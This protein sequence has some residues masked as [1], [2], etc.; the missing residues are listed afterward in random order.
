MDIEIQKRLVIGIFAS[1]TFV[2]SLASAETVD[3]WIMRAYEGKA[4]PNYCAEK[5]IAADP[6]NPKGYYIRGLFVVENPRADEAALKGAVADLNKA[7]E[8]APNMADALVARA[9][10]HE[11]LGETT[12]AEKDLQQAR[13]LRKTG[14]TYELSQLDEQIKVKHGNPNVLMD[15]AFTRMRSGDYRGAISDFEAYQAA[16]GGSHNS[17]VF[18]FKASAFESLGDIDGAIAAYTEG[19]HYFPEYPRL[20][21]QRGRVR[22]IAGDKEGCVRDQLKYQDLV[23]EGKRRRIAELSEAIDRDSRLTYLLEERAKI[24]IDLGEYD[25]AEKD[26]KAM[27]ESDPLDFQTKRLKRMLEER[28]KQHNEM[29]GSVKDTQ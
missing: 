15:R 6:T 16:V 4:E 22:A 8:L 3:D 18:T 19:I 13:V 20:Y 2:A 10:A 12:A 24:L 11:R 27:E 17:Q 29:N 23:K 5:A 25:L 28:I 26:I 14:K 7:L 9:D 1:L 21:E